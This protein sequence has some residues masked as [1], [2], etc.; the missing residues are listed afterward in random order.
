MATVTVT[1]RTVDDAGSPADIDGVLVRVFDAP[2]DTYITEGTTGSVTSGEVDFSLFGNAGGVDYT[3][4]LSKSGVSFPPAPSKLIT[5]KD[6]AVPINTFQ[7]TGHIGL[8]GEIV[9]FVV[10]TDDT[11]PVPV[12]G[13]TVRIFDAADTFL[14]EALTNAAGEVSYV[15]EGDPDP[16]RT[17]IIRL[18]PLDGQTVVG[19]PT[20]LIQVHEPLVGPATNIFDFTTSEDELPA[21]TNP[22]MCLMTG[23]LVDQALRPMAKTN[24]RFIPLL[25]D[26]DAK[27]SGFP[28]PSDPAIVQQQMLLREAVFET[29]SDGSVQVLLPRK[30]IYDVHIHGFELPG[31]PTIAQVQIP[32]STSARLEDVLFP[33]VATLTWGTDTLGV[34][35]ED[36]EELTLA[37]TGS[38]DQVIAAQEALEALLEFSVDDDSIAL[39][40]LNADGNLLVTGLAVG[41]T[42]L[43]VARISGTYAPRVPAVPGLITAPSATV[44]I[45]V[46]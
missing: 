34:A 7:F 25:C 29:A 27:V 14:T 35:L 2:G 26:P 46:T 42:T 39:V 13:V 3:I 44:T 30:A 41:V 4:V 22:N 43:S 11:I 10:Q 32:D 24:L 38:N 1:I 16:G 33:Y 17:Y 12:E 31:I 45:T 23:T 28:F 6:P 21:S 19:G 40:K 8:E 5:V 15:L 9:K 37:V 36:T 20:Q 18:R